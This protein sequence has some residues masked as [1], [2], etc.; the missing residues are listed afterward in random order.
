M[1]TRHRADRRQLEL[2]REREEQSIDKAKYRTHDNKVPI[3][4]AVG[5]LMVLLSRY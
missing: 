3:L 2:H 4:G 5:M 1:H